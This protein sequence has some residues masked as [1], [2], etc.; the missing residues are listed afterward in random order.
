MLHATDAN[1]HQVFQRNSISSNEVFSPSEII[2]ALMLLNNE[3]LFKQV[4][5][6]SKMYY[7]NDPIKCLC[8]SICYAR[9]E[10][11]SE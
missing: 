10:K 4:E 6:L 7:Q 1:N 3:S 2:L 11:N 9:D 5:L 8:W